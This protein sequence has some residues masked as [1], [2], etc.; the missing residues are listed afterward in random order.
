MRNFL[1][2]HFSTLLLYRA[3]RIVRFVTI[4]SAVLVSLT[5]VAKAQTPEKLA[6]IN[7]YAGMHRIISE[8]AQTPPERA[9][10][11]MWRRTLAP[12][13]GMLFVFPD[14]AFHCFWMRN[15]YIPL[16]IAFLKNDG[17]IVNIED[18]QPLDESSHCPQE[19]IRLAIEVNQGWFA[20]RGIK[21][22]L[23]IR[24]LPPF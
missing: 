4:L 18:M 7:L 12:N 22:G 19:P 8:V 2:D 10:G 9:K 21:P 3:A 1:T 24:G 17:T 20:E 6:T 5:G 11:L 16:S 23:V 14:Q 13:E 15:T